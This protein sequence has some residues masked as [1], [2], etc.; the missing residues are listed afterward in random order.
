MKRINFILLLM[1]F[2]FLNSVA[3]AADVYLRNGFVF[4]NVSVIDTTAAVVN[5]ATDKRMI[6]VKLDDI[7]KIEKREVAPNEKSAYEMYSKSTNEEF[8][9]AE[10]SREKQ[11]A[12]RSTQL[13]A[14]GSAAVKDSLLRVEQRVKGINIL[15]RDGQTVDGELLAV[16]ESTIVVSTK[17]NLEEQELI[18]NM[19]SILVLNNRDVVHLSVKWESKILSIAGNS[20]LGFAGFGAILG[21]LLGGDH[22][23]FIS[24]PRHEIALYEAVVLG[25]VG[26][27]V[28]LVFGFMSNISENLAHHF[29][30]PLT[31]NDLLKLKPIARYPIN[32]PDWLQRIQ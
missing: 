8:L 22:G 19:N 15:L 18:N 25:V 30:G 20:F 14:Q 1:G 2:L 12:E 6:A 28:G 11:R 17:T 26:G 27:V 13:S 23:E 4:R 21:L 5:I 31:H 24:I 9:M 3:R 16:R 32:E 29:V 7:V 10:S